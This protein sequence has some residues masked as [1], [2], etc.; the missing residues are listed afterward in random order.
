MNR[1]HGV[2]LPYNYM[3]KAQWQQILPACGLRVVNW[4]QALR[5]YPRPFN[6]L[7]AQGLHFV[8]LCDK[9]CVSSRVTGGAKTQSR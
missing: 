2:S 4:N 9:T 1:A 7:F 8:G 5:L 6:L 3:S